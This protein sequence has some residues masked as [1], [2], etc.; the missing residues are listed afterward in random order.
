MT[1]ACVSQIQIRMLSE[2]VQDA[3]P[4]GTVTLNVSSRTGAHTKSIA[5]ILTSTAHLA[6]FPNSS[7]T[8]SST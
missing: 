5:R 2:D 1:S 8:K 3:F 7:L 6:N 4:I